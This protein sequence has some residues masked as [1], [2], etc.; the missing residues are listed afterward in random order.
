MIKPVKLP[1]WIS[2]KFG[3][4]SQYAKF[5]RHSGIDYAVP[6]NRTVYSPVKGTIVYAQKHSTGGNMVMIKDGKGNV[7]RLMHNNSFIKKSGSVAQGEPVA[8]AGT[9]GL[10][11]GVHVHHDICKVMWPTSFSQFFNPSTYTDIKTP[12]YP[13]WVKVVSRGGAYVRSKPTTA[14]S[15]A[16]SRYLPYLTPFRVSGVVTG[17]SINGNNKWYKSMYG[18]YIWSGNIK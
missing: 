11:T 5:G 3:V 17:Q 7:H 14:S 9:T 8:K 13:K 1:Y 15:L 10:S 18:N 4:P 6:L 12:A 16:G 2:T